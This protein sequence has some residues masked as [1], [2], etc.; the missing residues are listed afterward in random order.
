MG[1]HPQRSSTDKTATKSS[2]LNF[3]VNISG[4]NKGAS[5]KK[6]GGSPVDQ[7]K[8]N[9]AEMIGPF[10]ISHAGLAAQARSTVAMLYGG[11]IL[12]SGLRNGTCILSTLWDIV[13]FVTMYALVMRQ[14]GYF[15][16]TADL[17]GDIIVAPVFSVAVLVAEKAISA[18]RKVL[19]AVV[20]LAV[21][22]LQE[23]ADNA[24]K[25][26]TNAD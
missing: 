7:A 10:V 16:E 23:V 12:I 25:A 1:E 9:S 14:F 3:H 22:A 11:L 13:Y 19:K 8:L 17:E 24:A 26:E 20:I 2:Q 5:I 21:E 6:A 18:L 4:Y 15:Q